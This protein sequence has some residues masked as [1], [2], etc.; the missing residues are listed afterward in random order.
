MQK[1]KDVP[2]GVS[3]GRRAAQKQKPAR[4][5]GAAGFVDVSAAFWGV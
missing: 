1:T 4:P 5:L 2:F 3:D